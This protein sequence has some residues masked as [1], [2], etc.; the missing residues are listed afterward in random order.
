[1]KRTIEIE[2]LGAKPEYMSH[3]YGILKLV[4]TTI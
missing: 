1:M 2:L 4:I 3:N